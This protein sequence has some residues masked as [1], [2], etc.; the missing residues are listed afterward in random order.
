MN[1]LF[2]DMGCEQQN[3]CTLMDTI[4]EGSFFSSGL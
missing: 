3:E 4:E 1:R 2:Y